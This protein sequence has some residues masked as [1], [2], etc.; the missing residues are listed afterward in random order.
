MNSKEDRFLVA[1]DSVVPSISGLLNKKF[2]VRCEIS[3]LLGLV[4]QG[5]SYLGFLLLQ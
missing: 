5:L 3:T 4:D 2:I 1:L